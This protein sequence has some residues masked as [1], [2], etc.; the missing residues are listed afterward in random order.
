MNGGGDDDVKENSGRGFDLLL[1]YLAAGFLLGSIPP[2]QGHQ[3]SLRQH[4]HLLATRTHEAY[5]GLIA[6]CLANVYAWRSYFTLATVDRP[7]FKSFSQSST[8]S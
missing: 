1:A 8:S 3:A 6:P 7:F 4:L 2:E 5:A